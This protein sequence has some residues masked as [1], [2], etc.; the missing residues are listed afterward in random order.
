[1][2]QYLK[3]CILLTA[4]TAAAGQAAPLPEPTPEKLPAWRGF[5]LLEKFMKGSSE[6]GPYREDDFRL[7][8]EW[9]FNFV[10]LPMDY[11][12]WIKDGDW[13]QIDE[14]AFADIDQAVAFGRKYNIH[15]CINFHRAPG[16]TVARPPEAKSLW[17]DPE[18][19]QVCAMHWAYL[20]RKST[21]LNSSHARTCA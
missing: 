14:A 20:D 12:F 17:T 4:I 15:I 10:R 7:I 19:R 18:A 13:T 21:R 2:I 9:G 6:S 11:R 1:M 3:I 8:A 5:N 16:Y